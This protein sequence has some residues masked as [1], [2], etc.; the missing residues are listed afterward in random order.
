MKGR[1]FISVS[2]ICASLCISAQMPS[3]EKLITD[4]IQADSM[5]IINQP[6][7]LAQRLVNKGGATE[8]AV[9]P[10]EPSNETSPAKDASVS[11][12][13]NTETSV[14]GTV[15]SAG[16]RVQVF[17]DNNA[18]SAKAEARSKAQAIQERLPQY[19]TYVVYQSP[20]WRLKV[21]DFLTQSE[22]ENAADEIKKIF[23]SFSREVRVVKDRINRQ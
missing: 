6:D 23:P 22:A 17:S 7:A 2:L 16:Y 11:G 20:Y 12:V 8:S 10:T 13:G 9:N 1:F 18:H 15:K 4:V 5:V 3:N 14:S 19:R 21:G